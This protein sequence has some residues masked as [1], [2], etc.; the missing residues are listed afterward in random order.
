MDYFLLD[1]ILYVIILFL[2]VLLNFDL[3]NDNL[4]CELSGIIWAY[5]YIYLCSTYSYIIGVLIFYFPVKIFV[6]D[7]YRAKPVFYLQIYLT[8]HCLKLFINSFVYFLFSSITP[9]LIFWQLS[10]CHLIGT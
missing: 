5:T 6:S 9:N 10:Y 3:I 8:S 4:K 7:A 2:V 1:L